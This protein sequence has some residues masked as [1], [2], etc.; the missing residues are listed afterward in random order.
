M[1]NKILFGS[2]GAII[3]LVAA[4]FFTDS[5][6]DELATF[7]KQVINPVVQLNRNCSGV[8]LDLENTKNTFLVTANHCVEGEK[9]GYV[10]LDTKATYHDPISDKDKRGALIETQSVVYDVVRRDL[11]ND[12]AVIK[13][14]KEG[15]E[16][17]GVTLAQED[18]QE[19]EQVW[20]VGYPLG[21]T[22]T[23]T[24]GFFGGYMNLTPDMHFD[25]FGNGRPVYRAT[26]PI[27]GGNSGGGMFVKND[28]HY[29]LVG[30]TDAGFQNFFVAGFY[31]PQEFINEIV[32]ET[33][34]KEAKT[35]TP[36]LVNAKKGNE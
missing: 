4:G 27:Y 36:S 26:P 11:V 17:D 22:R 29:E 33:L 35:E 32:K 7:Q 9:S 1:R 18:P 6:A 16:L 5:K 20:T 8:V 31:N 34:K 24:E 10:T 15:L 21:L 2:L 28:D 23:V 30:I 3:I 13:T 25:E 19:G 12:L 14:R